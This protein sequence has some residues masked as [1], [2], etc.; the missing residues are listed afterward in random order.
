[1][2]KL[3]PKINSTIDDLKMVMKVCENQ[4]YHVSVERLSNA[5]DLLEVLK[6]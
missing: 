1:M 4:G 6:K 3:S 5:I 2:N